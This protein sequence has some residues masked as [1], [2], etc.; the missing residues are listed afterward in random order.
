V[1]AADYVAA[2]E[3][4]Y[5]PDATMQDNQQPPRLGLSG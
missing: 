3:Q 5:H 2:L 1:E 4:F